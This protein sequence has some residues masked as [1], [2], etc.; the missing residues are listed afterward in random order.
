VYKT[1]LE[2]STLLVL[3]SPFRSFFANSSAISMA[4]LMGSG[5]CVS[6]S[7]NCSLSSAVS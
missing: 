7:W 2:T 5:S 3:D 6:N 4:S 1:L